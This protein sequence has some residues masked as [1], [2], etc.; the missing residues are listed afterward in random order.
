MTTRLD[1]ILINAI[2]AAQARFENPVKAAEEAAQAYAAGCAAYVAATSPAIGQE[3][4]KFICA[5][6]G[7]AEGCPCQEPYKRRID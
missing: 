2:L 5:A 3:Q 1:T 7:P 4:H 6:S